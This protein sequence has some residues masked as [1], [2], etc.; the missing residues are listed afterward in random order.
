ME[1]TFF[2]QYTRD[3]H[4]KVS[5]EFEDREE[6]MRNLSILTV[7]TLALFAAT[8]MQNA[9]ELWGSADHHGTGMK[10]NHD[11]ADLSSGQAVYE[12]VCSA[13]HDTGV[14]GAIKMSDKATWR[15]HIHHGVDHMVESVIKGK[16]AM[17]ARGGDPNLSDQEVEAA[18]HYIVE[19]AQ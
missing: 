4:E 16:G 8:S 5:L 7:S 1:D 6:L 15:E 18:V 17:P 9:S 11:D 3:Q 2:L 10:Q 14:A 19:K 12:R 13:C